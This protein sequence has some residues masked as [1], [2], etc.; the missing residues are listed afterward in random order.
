MSNKLTYRTLS[1]EDFPG[2]EDWIETLLKPLNSS[3]T[4]IGNAFDSGLTLD[5]LDAEIIEREFTYT[6][7]GTFPMFLPIKI[8]HTPRA[9]TCVYAFN[10]T[11]TESPPNFTTA[12]FVSWDIAPLD[13][14]QAIR[15]GNITGLTATTDYRLRFKIE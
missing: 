15:I 1:R 11:S 13:G 14:K 12:I 3:F 4:A 7:S 9:V 5:N 8:K 10:R 2:Q 6:G